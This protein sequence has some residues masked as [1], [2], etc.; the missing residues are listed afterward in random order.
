LAV[1]S[2][3]TTQVDFNRPLLHQADLLRTATLVIP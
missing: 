3:G 1:I 2:I